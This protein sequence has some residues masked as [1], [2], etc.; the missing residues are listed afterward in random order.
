MTQEYNL[1]T[2]WQLK[3]LWWKNQVHNCNQSAKVPIYSTFTGEWY[4]ES[5]SLS[6]SQ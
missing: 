5:W 4:H 3:Q 2:V 6:Q 1:F